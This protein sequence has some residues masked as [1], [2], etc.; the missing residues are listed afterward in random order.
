M[1]NLFML[2][3][4]LMVSVCAMADDKVEPL[5]F[6]P[7]SIEDQRYGD[8]GV[9]IDVTKI[10]RGVYIIAVEGWST[11]YPKTAE[12]AKEI[13]KAKGLKVVDKPEDADIGFMLVAGQRLGS[14]ALIEEDVGTSSEAGRMGAQLLYAAG[15]NLVTGMFTATITEHFSANKKRSGGY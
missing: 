3:V 2:F 11:V 5:V 8:T 6:N 10:T 13:F 1:K 4:P 7:I 15:F 14:F 12:L 9:K